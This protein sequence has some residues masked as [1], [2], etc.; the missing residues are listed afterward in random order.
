MRVAD[1][2]R[3]RGGARSPRPRPVW[4]RLA[5]AVPVVVLT[6]A[7]CTSPSTP[8]TPPTT[9]PTAPSTSA[10]IS[11]P[12]SVHATA[13]RVVAVEVAPFPEGPVGEARRGDPDSSSVFALLPST[14]PDTLAQPADCT[15][16]V[17]VIL[18]LDDGTH[19]P[20]GPCTR[21]AAIEVIRCALHED[22]AGC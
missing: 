21:P 22:A 10:A 5:A 8:T 14:L 1:R 11:P 9:S 18:T 13:G 17:T 3:L 16:G 15:I 7:A 6:A 4:W 20:Y 12:V 19:I 2:R